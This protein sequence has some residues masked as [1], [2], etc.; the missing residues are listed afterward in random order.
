MATFAPKVPVFCIVR[1]RWY[2]TI[3]VF[4]GRDWL[5]KTYEPWF[6][7]T[8]G[9]ATVPLVETGPKPPTEGGSAPPVP[10]PRMDQVLA[11]LAALE[12]TTPGGG[13]TSA[14]DPRVDGLLA[15]I[16]ALETQAG[17]TDKAV[18]AAVA[19]VEQAE[20]KVTQAHFAAT[21]AQGT[22]NRV[23]AI[24]TQ[25]KKVTD[26]VGPL[27]LH[28][29]Y[30]Q[31]K[32]NAEKAANDAADAKSTAE[33]VQSRFEEANQE[34]EL[35]KAGMQNAA[36][37]IG[38]LSGKVDDAEGAA[39]IAKT[40]AAEALKKATKAASDASTANLS[41]NQA[42]KTLSDYV[43]A[44]PA[45]KIGQLLRAADDGFPLR[46]H[47]EKQLENNVHLTNDELNGFSIA[48]ANQGTT[49]WLW[50]ADQDLDQPVVTL[51][52]G[53]S[54]LLIGDGENVAAMNLQTGT[55]GIFVGGMTVTTSSGGSG[56][57]WVARPSTKPKA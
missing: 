25:V 38:E 53:Q 16:A 13:G 39:A 24:V 54:A 8:S 29:S 19:R 12:T 3:D 26:R 5:V 6:V 4:D 18:K 49:L 27:N 10:D 43:S 41:A 14:P 33:T 7:E 36:R 28:E 15:K 46:E 35:V 55:G 48:S 1:G 2:S 50:E 17:D 34:V 9:P 45:D 21:D 52:D 44:A 40:N 30:A 31:V 37:T 23:S 51:D 11:R 32:A 20:T 57:L 47:Q 56:R 22:A 42:V